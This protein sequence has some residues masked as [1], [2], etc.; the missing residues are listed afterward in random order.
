MSERSGPASGRIVGLLVLIAAC[1]TILV[2]TGWLPLSFSGAETASDGTTANDSATS[3]SSDDGHAHGDDAHAGHNHAH[4]GHS[5]A[6]HSHAGHSHAG[7]SHAG[8]DPHGAD[9]GVDHESNALRLSAEALR[10]VGLQ[11]EQIRT[12]QLT[13]FWPVVSL[14]AQVTE[15]AGRTQ[16]QVSA[17]MTGIV[18]EVCVTEGAAVTPGTLLFRIRLTHEDLLQLQTEFLQT[19]EELDVE[20]REIRRLEEVTRNQAIPRR[21]LLER[22]YQRDKLTA[23]RDA[24]QES[25]RLHGLTEEHLQSII[26]NRQLV[27]ELQLYAP[28]A[29]QTAPAEADQQ[30]TADRVQNAERASGDESQNPLVLEQL[31]V[32]QGQVV[33]A[34]TT[35]CVLKD[36]GELLIEGLAFDQHVP[37]LRTALQEQREVTAVFAGPGQTHQVVN[38]LHIEHLV[39]AV[40]SESRSL[41]FLVRLPNQLASD[42]QR[43]NL[44]FVEWQWLTG[45]RLQLRIPL[46][47]WKH[48]IVL[49]EQA[50]AREGNEHYVFRQHGEHFDRVSIRIKHRDPLYVVVERDGAISPG[51]VIAWRGADLMQLALRRGSTAPV[52]P[53]HGHTH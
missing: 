43:G 38:G 36:Y 23:L 1:V 47:R 2:A 6:G 35:L 27:R 20:E 26:D 45:Q 46:R 28:G 29:D 40:D 42:R 12:V 7:H 53:H 3:G 34:G 50:V 5:H 52:D 32:H 21:L 30:P 49:P 39:N 16:L 41:R 19:I 24:Q 10:T 22:E 9:G 15:R 11:D 37:A 33:S 8:H 18:M 14:P 17:P 51:N 4:A 48:Q 31:N 44:R 13:T 25:L